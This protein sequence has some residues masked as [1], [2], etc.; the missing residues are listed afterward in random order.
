MQ[1]IKDLEIM[2]AEH[3]LPCRVSFNSPKSDLEKEYVAMSRSAFRFLSLL[4][5]IEKF[6]RRLVLIAPV[7]IYTVIVRISQFFEYMICN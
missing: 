7:V 1:S 5:S 4:F 2:L 6:A 3:P